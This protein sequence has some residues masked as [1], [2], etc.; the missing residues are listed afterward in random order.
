MANH[1]SSCDGS[2]SICQKLFEA[3]NQR[4]EN[5]IYEQQDN[6]CKFKATGARKAFAW[7]NTHGSRSPKIEIWFLGDLDA[8][9]KFSTLTIRPRKP[10]NS[11]WGEYHGRFNVENAKQLEQAVELLASISCPYST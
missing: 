5:L 3:L 10:T 8:A 4:I 11:S 2:K 1:S 6:K 9:R 7:I